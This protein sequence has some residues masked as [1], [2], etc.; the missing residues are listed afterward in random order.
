[1]KDELELFITFLRDER[2]YSS[3]TIEAYKRDILQFLCFFKNRNNLKNEIKIQ[4]IT[5]QDIRRWLAE[6]LKTKKRTSVSRKLA[7]L[8]SF[9]KFLVREDIIKKDPT[10]FISNPKTPRSLPVSLSVDET[11]SLVEAPKGSDFISIRDKAILELLYSTGIRVSEL[12]GL[13][14]DNVN[15][16]P[17][18]VKVKGKGNK[19]RIVPFG[20]KAKEALLKYIKEREIVIRQKKRFNESALFINRLGSRLTRRSVARILY[21]YRLISGTFKSATPHTLRHT[22]ATHLLESGA[23]LRAIQ[24]ILGH[25][26]LITTELY[27]HL[28]LT[29]LANVYDK[30]HPRAKNLKKPIGVRH[31][32]E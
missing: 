8:R 2:N 29:R 15:F 5:E 23:D 12:V 31:E 3:N 1:M 6:E 24:E 10:L 27:T 19:E 20:K 11:F 21:K 7:S 18:M 26:S 25:K 30:A 9:F 16:S 28:D 32:S 13:N 4:D 22:M 17:E 14:L